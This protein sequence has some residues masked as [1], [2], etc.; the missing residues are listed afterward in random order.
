ME[1]ESDG[2]TELLFAMRLLLLLSISLLILLSLLLS[3][4][5]LSLLLLSE[6]IGCLLIRYLR[7]LTNSSTGTRLLNGGAFG[8]VLGNPSRV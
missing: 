3:S 1:D 4:L 2:E 5:K 6:F 8:S 7:R